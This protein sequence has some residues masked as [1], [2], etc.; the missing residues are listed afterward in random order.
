PQ[1]AVAVWVGRA[2]GGVPMRT[3]NGGDPVTGGSIPAR[4]WASFMQ[5]ALADAPAA[6]FE[7]QTPEYQ[8]VRVD[9]TSGLLAGV[10]CADAVETPFL[11][12][13]APTGQATGC[14]ERQRRI[15]DL[16]GM[17]VDDARAELE[18]EQFARP[19]LEERLVTSGDQHSV[20]LAQDPP[21]GTFIWRDD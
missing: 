14:D 12:G 18:A 11:K 8:T 5:T 17:S 4:I 15:P 2:E 10:W 3:Q 1:L 7:L 9:P 6:E 13:K 16:V 21:A 19:A 20:V